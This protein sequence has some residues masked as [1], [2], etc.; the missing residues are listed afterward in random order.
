MSLGLTLLTMCIA[1]AIQQMSR[2]AFLMAKKL[3]K[4]NG[5]DGG[6]MDVV[7]VVKRVPDF[8]AWVREQ[9]MKK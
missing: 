9:R 1:L 6:T 2:N 3:R 5:E 7:Q 8:E 4:D